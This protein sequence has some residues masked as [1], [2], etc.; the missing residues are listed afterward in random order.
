MDIKINEVLASHTGTDN[1]EFIELFALPG[2]SLAGLSLIVIE[3][4]SSDAGS[5]DRRIDFGADDFVGE[6]G[7][8]LIG[9]PEGLNA[10]YNTVPDWEIG[11]NF[12]ENSSLT[13]ALV[14][15]S[16]LTTNFVTGNEVVLDA[17]AITDG[18][19][20]DTFF[21]NAPV[22][23][24]DGSFFP[25][26][27]RRIEDGVD[28]DTAADFVISDFDLAPDNTPTA[29]TSNS[30]NG[31]TTGPLSAIGRVKL[32]DGAEINAFDPESKK[33]KDDSKGFATVE[34]FELQEIGP[35]TNADGVPLETPA[36][37]TIDIGG[38]SG[39]FF[40][41]QEGN[42]LK[43][44]SIPDRG[45]NPATFQEDV[46]KDGTDDTVRP[47]AL[48]DYQAR[49]VHIE[50]DTSTGVASIASQTF[51]TRRVD[52]EDEGD[53]REWRFGGDDDD[54]DDDDDSRL[55]PITGSPNIVFDKKGNQIDEFPVDPN[56]DPVKLDPF[57][58]DMEGIVID[59]RDGSFWTVD[60]YR[61]AISR[62]RLI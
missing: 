38:F 48:P 51:L 30:D 53:D 28:T 49:I 39:L 34:N 45:P 61:P 47:L 19:V 14:E 43:F 50:L 9:N 24:P 22:I 5:I 4:D 6:N 3:G 12:L 16:S 23:G 46:N 52:D 40:A 18:D 54:D 42:I 26:G 58:G 25:A 2:T 31:A 11:N 10:N 59:S 62:N 17:V 60:E 13:I 29:S 8:F 15:T 7:F 55:V 36:G 37:Q 21:F 1:T 44:V 32:T 27:V 57:G 56:G 33:L 41:G 20:G 35:I